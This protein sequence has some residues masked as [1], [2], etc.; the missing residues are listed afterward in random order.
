[1]GLW[2]AGPLCVAGHQPLIAV[3][4]LVACGAQVLGTRASVAATCRL[5]GVCASVVGAQLLISCV[6]GPGV[7][8]LQQL[9]VCAGPVAPWHVESSQMSNP[10]SLHWQVD[11]YA[12][13]HK[14]NLLSRLLMH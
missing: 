9:C 14:G 11:S 12:Y 13:C 5:Q 6:V 10:C 2:R 1:M 4:S 7:Y 8:R 3:A